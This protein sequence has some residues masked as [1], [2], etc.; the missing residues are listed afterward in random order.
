MF[1]F[2]VAMHADR[3]LVSAKGAAYVFRRDGTSWVQEARLPAAEH[4]GSPS[5][6]VALDDNYAVMGFRGLGRQPAMAGS[7]RV[8]QHVEGRWANE[9]H[10]AASDAR[11]GDLF[12]SSVAIAG[13]F[14]VIGAPRSA[15][16]VEESGATYVFEP[17]DGRWVETAKLFAGDGSPLDGFGYQVAV[18]GERIVVGAMRAANSGAAYIFTRRKGSGWVLEDKLT[19]RDARGIAAFGSS[20]AIDGT[21]VAV[22]ALLDDSTGGAGATYVFDRLDGSWVQ[23]ARLG[24]CDARWRDFNGMAV[25]T[26]GGKVVAGAMGR[27]SSEEEAGSVYVWTL[28]I[29]Q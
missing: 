15:G 13:P 11:A 2:A 12:G 29:G 1:G 3:C 22:G 4:D 9:E 17:L 16:V 27:D 14:L 20:V 7:A 8:F 21:R 24:A 18:D 25:A 28:P 10:L 26:K 5:L 6:A 19:P 23:T